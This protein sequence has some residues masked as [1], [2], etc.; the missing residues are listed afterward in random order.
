MK[1]RTPLTPD[2]TPL[3]DVVFILLIFFLVSATFKKNERV[4]N[5]SLPTSTQAQKS[6]EKTPI[7]IELS[8][9]ALAY[10]GKIIKFSELEKY[11]GV[12]TQKEKA[13]D[14]IID[15]SVRYQRIV[16]ILDM[17]KKYRLYNLALTSKTE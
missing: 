12:I 5:L 15:K 9:D 7:R 11:L 2:I 8:E 17:L 16:K 4:L 6:P 13:V 1:R 14:L 3:I 10:N